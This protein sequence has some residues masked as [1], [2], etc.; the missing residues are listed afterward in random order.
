MKVKS[1]SE[2]AQS[3]LTLRD[4]MDC[5]LPGSSAHRIFQARVLEWD[6]IAFPNQKAVKQRSFPT[7]LTVS[8]MVE[9]GLALKSDKCGLQFW[10]LHLLSEQSLTESPPEPQFLYLC[11]GNYSIMV[12]LVAQMIKNLPA[13]QET[14]AQSLG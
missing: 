10:T 7:D 13:M 3:C 8:I 5:I 2:V 12:S 9:R 1:E 11:Y 6:A 4:P 14:W